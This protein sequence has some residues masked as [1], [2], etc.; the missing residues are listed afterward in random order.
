M[1]EAA[2][3]VHFCKLLFTKITITFQRWSLML[4]LPAWNYSVGLK[5]SPAKTSKQNKKEE[6][7]E[8]KHCEIISTVR[9]GGGG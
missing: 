8:K 3:F 9:R 5:G 1:S 7:K 2:V 4:G 6:N